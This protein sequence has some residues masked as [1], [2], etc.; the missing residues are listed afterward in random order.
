[1]VR[2]KASK[3]GCRL[4]LEWER[5]RVF[6]QQVGIMFQRKVHEAGELTV[7]GKKKCSVGGGAGGRGYLPASNR[8]AG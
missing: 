5:G 2:P 7:S 1:M 3:G 8:A 4:D 6:D